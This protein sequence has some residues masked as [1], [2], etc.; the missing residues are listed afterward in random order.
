MSRRWNELSRR[1]RRF[2]I[3]AAVVET[4]LKA[5][6]VNDLRRR[7]ADQ[8]RGPKWLWAAS[9]VVNSAGIVPAAYFLV[10]RAR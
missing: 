7:P 2:V 4:A 3:A 1:Q 10:G 9:V 5:A 8:I 6:M